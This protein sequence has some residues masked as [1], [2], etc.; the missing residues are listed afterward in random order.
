ML[1]FHRCLEVSKEKNIRKQ[2]DPAKMASAVGAVK[3]GEM[4]YLKAANCTV[5][6]R[7]H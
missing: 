4:V 1:V 5:C 7:R 2:W 6:H 3:K